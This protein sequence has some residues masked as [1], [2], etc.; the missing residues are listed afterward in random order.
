MDKEIDDDKRPMR[1]ERHHPDHYGPF[2]WMKNSHNL[3][4]FAPILVC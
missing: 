2:S 4:L 3:L 1:L